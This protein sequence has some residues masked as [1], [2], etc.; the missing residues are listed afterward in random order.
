MN[1]T[2]KFI[3]VKQDQK[4]DRQVS[5][6]FIIHR[7]QYHIKY[8][9]ITPDI[10]YCMNNSTIHNSLPSDICLDTFVAKRWQQFS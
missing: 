4:S 6:H 1:V 2:R 8:A 3:L 10:K 9:T 5:K 7:N